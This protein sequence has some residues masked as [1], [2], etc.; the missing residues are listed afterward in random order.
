[1]SDTEESASLR[2]ATAQAKLDAARR[3]REFATAR[4]KDARTELAAAKYS[5][6]RHR[7]DQRARELLRLTERAGELFVAGA[8]MRQVSATLGIRKPY[9]ALRLLV[10]YLSGVHRS[11]RS[12]GGDCTV[13]AV[14]AGIHTPYAYSV[15]A[16]GQCPFCEREEYESSTEKRQQEAIA[17]RRQGTV[18][19]TAHACPTTDE[20]HC[21]DATVSDAC[22]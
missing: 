5:L 11:A 6:Q 19:R 8:S 7:D 10:R 4:V 3:E 12:D 13:V 21:D 9:T 16:H 18:Q 14:A 22:R 1:M 17:D 15:V 2:V 20:C